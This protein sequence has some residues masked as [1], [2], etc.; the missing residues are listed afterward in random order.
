MVKSKIT[1]IHIK[2]SAVEL[3]TCHMLLS[4]ITDQKDAWTD[5]DKQTFIQLLIIFI[6]RFF[7]KKSVMQIVAVLMLARSAHSNA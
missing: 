2:Q 6:F 3:L 7:W 5:H 1:E 4:L